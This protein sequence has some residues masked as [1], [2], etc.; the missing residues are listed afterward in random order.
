MTSPLDTTY[1]ITL[2]LKLK[3]DCA[4][5]GLP[6]ETLAQAISEALADYRQV[7]LTV[8]GDDE[9]FIKEATLVNVG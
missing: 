6:S 2:T 3:V 8:V 4:N 5:F 7:P 1:E 9:D